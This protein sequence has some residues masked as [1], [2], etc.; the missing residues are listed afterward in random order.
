MPSG[1]WSV[2]STTESVGEGAGEAS[3][4]LV[5]AH[6]A[7]GDRYAGAD[8]PGDAS[9]PLS[10]VAPPGVTLANLRQVFVVGRQEL[11]DAGKGLVLAV[12]PGNIGANVVLEDIE[13]PT[14]LCRPGMVL[15]FSSD[16]SRGPVLICMSTGR[17][18]DLFPGVEGP[19]ADMQLGVGCI[20]YAGGIVRPRDDL[21]VWRQEPQV[22]DGK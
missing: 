3:A 2:R 12:T 16:G 17:I 6:G 1:C 15:R 4:K 13:C 8:M 14:K 5:S 18:G 20:V 21:D 22:V 9:W 10:Q 11:E 7:A 19:E